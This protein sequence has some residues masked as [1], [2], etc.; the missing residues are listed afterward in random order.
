MP[1][2]SVTTRG[3]W[4]A[5]LVPGIGP[6]LGLMMILA[7]LP[8]GL[9]AIGQT[10]RVS[11]QARKVALDAILGETVQA[12]SEEIRI[13]QS[14]QT[15]ARVL[16]QAVVPHLD[17]P[18][19]CRAMMDAAA[20]A[21]PEASLVAYV[22]LS[23]LM[24]CASDGHRFDFNGQPL[25]DDMAGSTDPVM[26]INRLGPVSGTSV[27]GISHPV[28]DAGGQRIG[29]VSI[30]VPHQTMEMSR[31]L[32]PDLTDD[33]VALITFDREGTVLTSTTG[34]EDA[35]T[36]L[37][38]GR[39]LAE[40]ADAGPIAFEGTSWRGSPRLFAVV[41]VQGDLFLL[42]SW[43]VQSATSGLTSSP[44]VFPVLMWVAG[45]AVALLASE[46][47]VTRH[48]RRLS[49]SMLAF[50]G[51]ARN[52]PPLRLDHPPTEIASLAE[53][54][55]TMTA[56]ILR[57]EADLEN[58]VHEKEVLLR[59][60][61]HRTGNSLQLIA[62]I[63]R[64]HLR[65]NPPE[66]MREILENLHDRV[67][68]LSTVHFG[69][70]RVAGR[71]EVPVDS[72]MSE[73]IAKIAAIH[74][75]FGRRDAIEADLAPLKLSPQQAVP[76]ALLLAEILSCFPATEPGE[77]VALVRV[78]LDTL[79]DDRACLA[80]TGSDTARGA[81]TGDGQGVPE[82]IAGRL[83][84]AFV[85][86][87]FGTMTVTDADGRVRVTITFPRRTETRTKPDLPAG[88]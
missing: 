13:I 36:R 62:S 16:A 64:M 63:L 34:V 5:G 61:H 58:L 59:E 60:V 30:S 31:R 45:L 68:S 3:G 4:L 15:A 67:M 23:G 10:V 75:R 29:F 44:Y 9:L 83:I 6:L 79:D 38:R 24:T 54:Y 11:D 88:T 18:A 43:P 2:P 27:V 42:G 28:F 53:T 55:A 22:P 19:A 74:G 26:V 32:S 85:L 1:P 37:P 46:R 65:E 33:P 8:L 40:L 12:A 21:E 57:D 25:F 48:L 80:I 76:L 51:G 49:R 47:L 71:S 52:L 7:L 17:D 20:L 50:T 14:A 39:P 77:D 72:L 86:Q 84:R 81:L 78:T 70:Y 56:T 35:P 73:V 41:P 69:L 66:E 82:I 87:I